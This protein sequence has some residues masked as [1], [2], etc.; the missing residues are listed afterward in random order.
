MLKQP[1]IVAI[2]DNVYKYLPGRRKKVVSRNVYWV[3]KILIICWI[4][5]YWNSCNG[6]NILHHMTWN[7]HRSIDSNAMLTSLMNFWVGRPLAPDV[8]LAKS[9]KWQTLICCCCWVISGTWRWSSD[10]L[11]LLVGG[12]RALPLCLILGA[13]GCLPG[14]S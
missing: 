4:C 10:A 2:I 1:T 11:D 9:I 12:G 6:Q 8:R 13:V 3:M 7:V 14:V 5:E